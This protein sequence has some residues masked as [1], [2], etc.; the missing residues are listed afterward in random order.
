MKK[1]L[2]PQIYGYAVCLAMT[3]V[4]IIGLVGLQEAV[5]R[6]VAPNK[7]YECSMYNNYAAYKISVSYPEAQVLSE[8]QYAVQKEECI[9]RGRYMALQDIV[10]NSLMVILAIFFFAWHWRWLHKEEK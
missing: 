7:G 3:I 4:G 6:Y 1:A 9:E 8:E 5:F 2:V 10:Q